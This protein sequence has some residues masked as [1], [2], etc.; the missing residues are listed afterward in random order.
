MPF[1]KSLAFKY[2][3]YHFKLVAVILLLSEIMLTYS[4][5][6]EKGLVYI[7]IIALF[8]WQ[9]SSYFECT[10]LNMHLSCNIY[11]ISNTKCIYL[12]IHFCTF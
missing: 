3:V 5:Y 9:P 1:V 4:Y 10:K 7:I 8:S 6:T 11:F 12:A 2:L